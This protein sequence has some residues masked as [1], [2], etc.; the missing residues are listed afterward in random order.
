MSKVDV[1]SIK[2]KSL[3]CYETEKATGRRYFT[4][5]VPQ[6]NDSVEVGGLKTASFTARNFKHKRRVVTNTGTTMTNKRNKIRNFQTSN[7]T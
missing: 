4:K 3:K 7:F 5:S 1:T 2:K 6:W